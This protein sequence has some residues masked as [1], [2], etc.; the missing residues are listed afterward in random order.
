MLVGSVVGYHL[1]FGPNRFSPGSLSVT[2]M[3]RKMRG[4]TTGIMLINNH[5]PLRFV[6]WSRQIKLESDGIIVAKI[7]RN[8]RFKSTDNPLCQA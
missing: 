3:P 4:P 1:G 5:Q 7:Y 2:V 6:S 8:G